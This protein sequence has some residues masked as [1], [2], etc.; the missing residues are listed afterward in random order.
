MRIECKEEGDTTRRAKA[1]FR[2]R[3][4]F[5]LA[6]VLCLGVG[7]GGPLAAWASPL[8]Q[9]LPPT[10]NPSSTRFTIAGEIAT[11]GGTIP[12]TGSGAFSGSDVMLD[13]EM[14]A[15]AGVGGPDKVTA[16]I[17]VAGGR[18]YMRATGI[19]PETDGKWYGTDIPPGEGGNLGGLMGIDPA[20]AQNAFRITGTS[21]ETLNGVATTRYNFEVDGEALMPPGSVP[22]GVEVE[23][24]TSGAIWIGDA[25]QYV[26]RFSMR[27]ESI[28]AVG[29]TRSFAR[30]EFTVNFSAF[31]TPITITPPAEFEPLSL[32]FAS[33]MPLGEVLGGIAGAPP[34]DM[35][36]MP[37]SGE[38]VAPW[39]G[40]L[41]AAVA[42]VTAGSC[43]RWRA[44]RRAHALVKE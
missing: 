16:S 10:K 28:A 14:S 8:G 27:T 37:R 44:S 32:D 12:V 33:T 35:V 29:E 43:L 11:N 15:P 20:L 41:V 3:V 31:D 25:D 24:T 42:L 40:L 39:G 4:S 22:E 19:A 17:I 18:L 13:V 38:P 6:L 30:I 26:H 21:K 1:M 9:P 36:G 2:I 7:L 34:G 5:F 23:T